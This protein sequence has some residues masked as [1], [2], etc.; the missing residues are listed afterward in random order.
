MVKRKSV[1][2]GSAE[3]IHDWFSFEKRKIASEWEHGKWLLNSLEVRGKNNI[4]GKKYDAEQ[5]KFV[6]DD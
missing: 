6:K 3:N 5:Q 1:S 4:D 2:G